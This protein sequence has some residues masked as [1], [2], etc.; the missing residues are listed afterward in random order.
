MK[1]K[2]EGGHN[3]TIYSRQVARALL[4]GKWNQLLEKDLYLL[5]IETLYSSSTD[6]PHQAHYPLF[7][8][9]GFT[10]TGYYKIIRKGAGVKN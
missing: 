10:L 9:L 2:S 3:C 6:R 8:Q 7:M 4:F 5:H 1:L